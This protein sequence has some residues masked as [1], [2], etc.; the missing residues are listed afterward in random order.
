MNDRIERL[1]RWGR[2]QKPECVPPEKLMDEAADEIE[3]LTA[4]VKDAFESGFEFGASNQIDEDEAWEYYAATEQETDDC[5][6]VPLSM[7]RA[8]TGVDDE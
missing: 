6:S 1:R 7:Y 3:R 2:T 4:K 8:Y 5:V